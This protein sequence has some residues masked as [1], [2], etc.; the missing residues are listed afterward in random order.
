MEPD[1]LDLIVIPSTYHTAQLYSDGT[2][3]ASIIVYL[4][5][6]FQYRTSNKLNAY[7][8]SKGTSG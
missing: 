1:A 2:G 7:M 4:D 8:C 5:D 6:H 3:L